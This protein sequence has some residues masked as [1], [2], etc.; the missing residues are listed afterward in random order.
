MDWG[1]MNTPTAV[2][3]HTCMGGTPPDSD[4]L[5]APSCGHA[6]LR[7]RLRF[8]LLASAC[9]LVTDA[10]LRFSWMLRFQQRIFPS[11]DHFVLATQFLEVFRRAIWNLLRVEWEHIKQER[12]ANV[13]TV[14]ESEADPFIP[15]P[16]SVQMTSINGHRE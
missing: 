2:L 16:R 4:V 11:K 7:P 9:I 3:A 5:K 1:M 15:S 13:K 10:V 6:V 8:G 12:A 14:E